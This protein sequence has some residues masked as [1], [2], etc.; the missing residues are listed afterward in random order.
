RAVAVHA[1]GYGVTPGD[2]EREH[3]EGQVGGEFAGNDIAVAHVRD[4]RIQRLHAQRER[5]EARQW[6]DPV[7]V[8]DDLRVGRYREELDLA[9][10]GRDA[11]G[12][13]SAATAATPAAATAALVDHGV[14]Q[15]G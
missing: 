3:L 2:L 6:I 1:D 13:A 11:G 10:E 8:E 7:H 5:A 12:A 14:A 9:G 4:H 15:H